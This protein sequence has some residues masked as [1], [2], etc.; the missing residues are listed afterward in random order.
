MEYSGHYEYSWSRENG[1][2]GY[3][4][5]NFTRTDGQSYPKSYDYD[6]GY[7]NTESQTSV[8]TQFIVKVDGK[9][10]YQSSSEFPTPAEQPDDKEIINGYQYFRVVQ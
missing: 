5:G 2:S 4:E 3:D 9:I 7:G 10:V 1:G 6:D 8:I